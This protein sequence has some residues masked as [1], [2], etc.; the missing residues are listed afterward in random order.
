VL[1]HLVD[2]DEVKLV[3]YDPSWAESFRAEREH[4]F[5]CLPTELLR[6]IEHFGSTAVPGMPAK[7]IVDMLVE[8][9]SLA[10]TR[11]RIVPVLVSQGYRHFW[12]PGWGAARGRYYVWFIK[13]NERGART[14]H[15]HMVEGD[16]EHWDRLLFRDLLITDEWAR[17]EYATLKSQLAA[18]HPGDRIAYTKGKTEFVTTMTKRAKSAF[19]VA[20][21]MACVL[22][23][24]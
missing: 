15:I 4:L 19:R 13:R 3:P 24:P 16:F 2:T 21:A 17:A 22:S 1:K 18:R 10:E 6:R 7:P 11:L 12:S 20:P 23:N 14:H 8:V 5:A 9:T